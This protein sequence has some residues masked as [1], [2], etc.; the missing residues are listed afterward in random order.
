MR[1]PHRTCQP[2]AFSWLYFSFFLICA[3]RVEGQ[4][5]DPAS[6]SPEV[7]LNRLDCFASAT[8]CTCTNITFDEAG[9]TGTIPHSVGNCLD[10]RELR[11]SGNWLEGSLPASLANL[12]SLEV[13]DVS[14]NINLRGSL[15]PDFFSQMAKLSVLDLSYFL[16]LHRRKSPNIACRAQATPA[17]RPDPHG[18]A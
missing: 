13:L 8:S 16:Y 7:V 6:N 10:L 3:H 14:T 5:P 17:I 2:S 15:P 4:T 12:S 18:K 1:A 9:L 11:L